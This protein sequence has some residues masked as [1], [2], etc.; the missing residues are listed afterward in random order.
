[1]RKAEKYF[2]MVGVPNEDR[3]KIVVMYVNGK[4]EF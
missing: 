4:A 2:E 3:M 1:L